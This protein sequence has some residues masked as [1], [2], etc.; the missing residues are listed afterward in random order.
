MMEHVEGAAAEVVHHDLL[1][2]FLIDA[3]GQS[4]G[5]RLVDDALDTSSPAILPASLVAWRCASVK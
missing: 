5:G 4:S 1:V 3:V 2:V